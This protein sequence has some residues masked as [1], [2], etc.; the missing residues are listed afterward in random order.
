MISDPSIPRYVRVRKRD[1]INELW[2]PDGAM[3]KSFP[4]IRVFQLGTTW[5]LA[6][7]VETKLKTGLVAQLAVT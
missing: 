2:V 7:W 1:E 4:T 5:P 6:G 3:P